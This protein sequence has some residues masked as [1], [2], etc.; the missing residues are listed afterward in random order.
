MAE[1][2]TESPPEV[3]KIPLPN[4]VESLP[5]QKK[6]LFEE[7]KQRFQKLKRWE[8]EEW[9][10]SEKADKKDVLSKVL[11]SPGTWPSVSWEEKGDG[12]EDKNYVET[13]EVKDAKKD[14]EKAQKEALD[15]LREK[16]I[17]EVASVKEGKNLD[18]LDPEAKKQVHVELIK[19]KVDPKKIP[20]N[21]SGEVRK[22]LFPNRG[23]ELSAEEE[24]KLQDA[25]I[26][27]YAEKLQKE[28]EDAIKKDR[29]SDPVGTSATDVLKWLDRKLCDAITLEELKVE[30]E[31]SEDESPIETVERVLSE[32]NLDEYAHILWGDFSMQKVAPEIRK[33]IILNSHFTPPDSIKS[34]VDSFKLAVKNGEFP[35]L[36]RSDFPEWPEWDQAYKDATEKLIEDN[37]WLNQ[38]DL[39]NAVK[40][41]QQSP[42]F[43]SSWGFDRSK[44]S[45]FLRFLADML[46]WFGAAME[47]MGIL[48]GDFWR[49]YN[50]ARNAQGGNINYTNNGVSWPGFEVNKTTNASDLISSAE[51]YLWRPYLMGGEGRKDI[52]WDPIDCSQLVVNSLKDVGCLPSWFDTTA[53]WFAEKSEMTGQ[54]DGKPGDFL[55]RTEWWSDHIAIITGG[56][57]SEGNYTTI[58]STSRNAAWSGVIK[59]TRKASPDW[60]MSG[61]KVYKN[62]FLEE[63]QP[64]LS[65]EDIPEWGEEKK[66]VPTHYW[67]KK[68]HDKEG[69]D[70]WTAKW[71]TKSWVS[72]FDKSWNPITPETH[73]YG[74]CAVDPAI[75]PL[76]SLI[77]ANGKKYYAVDIWTHVTEAKA[78]KSRW[79]PSLPVVDFFSKDPV[80][81]EWRGLSMGIK[82]L[83]PESSDR[84]LADLK[85]WFVPRSIPEIDKNLSWNA[86]EIVNFALDACKRGDIMNAKHCTDWVDIIFKKVKGNS[87]YNSY[88]HFNGVSKKST[89]RWT[90]I[91]VDRYAWPDFVSKII[92][93]QHL[94][95]DK[96]GKSGSYGIWRT[97]SVITLW[98]PDAAGNIKVVS[99]PNGK[100]PPRIETYNLYWK[101]GNW[102]KN[103][104]VL[105][106]QWP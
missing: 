5:F 33:I 60:T 14:I 76:G 45:P 36:E 43:Q 6:R 18:S 91:W 30:P 69:V 93:W 51:K 2:K 28:Y 101:W 44:L 89:N 75:I 85:K 100:I 22:K 20:E 19:N 21:I 34:S 88:T 15:A 26:R 31:S 7:K 55:I 35:S 39:G 3:K 1:K 48:P 16:H 72:L 4:G 50:W 105:R 12:D 98:S 96:P 82:V 63:N 24:L 95:V 42:E 66:V 8:K 86:K 59:T 79:L 62:P 70:K 68:E 77:I 87:V 83:P 90:G 52:P 41:I 47:E 92:A 65:N 94:I 56:P 46:S 9:D 97:H 74:F 102:V 40:K 10:S 61:F 71:Q 27:M 25:S 23:S 67:H 38:N 84:K 78:A 64:D 80:W 13:Q 103:G 58:E 54:M 37:T 29:E 57:D 49:R 81:P 11:K 104:K 53:S 99:Y 106:I 32:R 73:G 17:S